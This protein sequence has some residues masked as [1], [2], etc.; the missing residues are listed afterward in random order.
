MDTSQNIKTQ[1]YIL[2]VAKLLYVLIVHFGQENSLNRKLML[3][4]K[5][6]A[7]VMIVQVCNRKLKPQIDGW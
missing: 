4:Q 2:G 1:D 3:K 7:V 5:A 6:N